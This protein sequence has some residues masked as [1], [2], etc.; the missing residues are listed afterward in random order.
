M[1]ASVTLAL[2][3]SV[4]AA[5]QAQETDDAP[6][7]EEPP[8][9]PLAK[10]VTDRPYSSEN[11][12]FARIPNV[13]APS[14]TETPITQAPSTITVLDGLELRRSGVR[15]L[16][17]ALRVVPGLEV[18]RMSSTESNV[19]ARGFHD[20]PSTAQG[21]LALVDGRVA[22]NEFFGNVLWD[23]LPV[24]LEEIDRIEVIRGPGSFVHG[25]N[26]MHGLVNIVT[27][28]PLDY[29]HDVLNVSGSYGS[30]DSSTANLTYVR[31][32]E[33]AAFKAT[34]GWDDID[35]FE[36]RDR[37]TSDKKFVEFRFDQML[38]DG[39]GR[40][41][42]TGG[43][44]EQKI[45][46]IIPVVAGI[47]SADL[48]NEIQETFVK[49]NYS[50]G[51]LKAQLFWT[52]FDA[53]SDPEQVYTAFD[54]D[55]DTIDLD[56]QYTATPWE[57]HTLTVG[58][59]YRFATFRTDD[60]DVADGRHDA[61]LA[62][63]FVQDE[64]ALGED[65]LLT[66]GLR[67]DWHSESGSNLSPRFAAVWQF[68]EDQHLRAS[69][70]FGFRNPSLREL[71]FDMPV[72]VPGLPAPVTIRGNDDLDAEEIQSFE[73]GY[74][75]KPVESLKAGVNGYYNRIDDLIVFRPVDFFP[76]PPFPPATPSAVA[77][78][79]ELDQEAYGVELELEYL[80]SDTVSGFANYAYGIRRD[81]DTNDRIET[82]PEQKANAGVRLSTPGGLQ[83]MLWV[84]YFDQVEFGGVPAD[85]YVLLNAQVSM[86]FR[87]GDTTGRA[88]VG[89][90]N[91]LDD[92]HREHPNG[93]RYG[94]ILRAGVS[95]TW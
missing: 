81:R 77:P 84:N 9:A 1:L 41:D 27:R 71:W 36:D 16:S 59:G 80:F 2:A 82:A 42:V 87:L 75:G 3:W 22:Y 53:D 6:E 37:N 51:N 29:E 30:Y 39:L 48:S 19:S 28:A 89:G 86:P 56:V 74:F 91:L 23:A 5:G 44:M 50:V 52:G 95:L 79:N 76:A 92:T 38:D 83:A 7:P 15:F 72:T 54:L 34:L 62:W 14:R 78:F 4:G 26:A 32:E 63:G 40:L 49:A 43:A 68:A 25:P 18:L 12:V 65:L 17:D 13:E 24:S 93:Q 35:P 94:A 67:L 57:N 64:I 10:A 11:A 70:G 21:M 66:A 58:S 60:S 46:V 55:L 33:D 8:A 45:D 90:F 47:P 88:F 69:A 31:R 61:S 20:A 85:D 73:L